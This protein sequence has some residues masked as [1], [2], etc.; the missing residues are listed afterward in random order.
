[1]KRERTVGRRLP[2][3][4]V[5]DLEAIAEAEQSDGSTT[6]RKFLFRAIQAGSWTTIRGCTASSHWQALPVRLESHSGK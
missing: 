5:R 6:V 3:S 1:M 4:A 2:D